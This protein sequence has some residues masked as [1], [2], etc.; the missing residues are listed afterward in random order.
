MICSLCGFSAKYCAVVHLGFCGRLRTVCSGTRI[1]WLYET[2]I[3][4][5]RREGEFV[6]SGV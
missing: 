3:N 4:P 1:L 2:K 5:F 6:D